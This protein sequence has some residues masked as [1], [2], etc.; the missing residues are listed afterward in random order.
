MCPKEQTLPK[1]HQANLIRGGL[2]IKKVRTKTW[3]NGKTKLF[4]CVIH[5]PLVY[6]LLMI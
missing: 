1:K 3:N 2:K 4:S 6:V 5:S